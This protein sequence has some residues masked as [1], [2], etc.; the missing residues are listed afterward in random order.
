MNRSQKF[1]ANLTE[2]KRMTNSASKTTVQL[3]RFLKYGF[4]V[5]IFAA[6]SALGLTTL[7]QTPAP[8][9]KPKSTAQGSTGTTAT[10]KPATSGTAAA[11]KAPTY[12][13]ALLHPALL[14]TRLLLTPPAL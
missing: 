8:A 14:V 1:D 10:K 11:A 3:S 13:R 2:K 6:S 7:A 12:D 5:A 4:A 9:A